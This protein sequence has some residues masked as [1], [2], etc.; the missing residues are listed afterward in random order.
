[1]PIWK[2]N[3]LR[4]SVGWGR[5]EIH[6]RNP[7][8]LSGSRRPYTLSERMVKAIARKRGKRAKVKEVTSEA[9]VEGLPIQKRADPRV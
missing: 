4:L 7:E 6:R 2:I 8:R 9:C 3:L 5:E 1:M